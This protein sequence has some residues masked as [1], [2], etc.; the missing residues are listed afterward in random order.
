MKLAD[1]KVEFLNEL[2]GCYPVEEINSFFSILASEYL[3]FTRF[4]V[5][6]NRDLL[7]IEEDATKFKKATQRLQKFEPIQY[8]IG[9][10]EFFSLPFLVNTSTLIPRPE[11]EDLVSWILNDIHEIEKTSQPLEIL[12]I[13]TGSGC[14]AISI[15]KNQ[16]KGRVSALDFSEKALI[17]ARQNAALNSAGIHFFQQDI[18]QAESLPQVYDII[19]SN[20]PYVRE[21]EKEAM[22][23]NVL[24][25]EPSS[26]LFVSDEDPFLFYKKIARLSLNYLKPGG[27]LY[28]EINEYL[29]KEL[30][31]LLE[32]MG[33]RE[34]TVKEDI[35][36][37][38]RMIK[39]KRNE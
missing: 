37:K 18:L 13:G 29:S 2:S 23:Q 30:K 5:V 8:I 38:D 25:F 34:V 12:D 20:P 14:I 11:T 19:V 35:F 6:Q 1:L 16:S 9:N 32:E 7:L 17:T 39:C 10:T 36:G 27:A 28:F 4:Q 26:A 15:A 31:E 21:L 22:H 3:G 33:F 24:N